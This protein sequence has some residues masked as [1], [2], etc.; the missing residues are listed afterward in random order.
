M[1]EFK[2]FNLQNAELSR[3]RQLRLLH[4]LSPWCPRCFLVLS[5]LQ[6]QFE[7]MPRLLKPSLATCIL[8]E[9]SILPL[10]RLP[11]QH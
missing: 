3:L 10:G 2:K 4:L 11:G 1:I 7:L 6:F 9:E 5:C 8:T